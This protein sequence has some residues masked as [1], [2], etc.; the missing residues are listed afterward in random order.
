MLVSF[1]FEEFEF[2]QIRPL[3][4]WLCCPAMLKWLLIGE[5][6]KPQ[7]AGA[8]KYGNGYVS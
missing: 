2:N 4:S 1:V 8:T 5:V 7:V 6:N 3:N